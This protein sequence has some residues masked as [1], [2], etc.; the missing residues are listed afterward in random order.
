[1]GVNGAAV[2][3]ATP[4]VLHVS[5]TGNDSAT[6]TNAAPMRTISAA[7]KRAPADGTVVVS[8]GTYHENVTILRTTPVH[9]ENAPGAE[10]WLDGSRS[11][12][13]W[14][15]ASGG[16]WVADN[17]T[18]SFDSSPTLK[19]GAPDGTAAG[20]QFI[21][22][23]YPMAAHPDQVWIDGAAQSQVGS[24][25]QVKPGSFYVDYSTS[26]LYLGSNPS[27]HVVR[28][29][30]LPKAISVRAPGT[31]IK[32]INVR[33]YAP[34]VPTMGAVTVERPDVSL[35]NMQIVDNATSGLQVGTNGV[36]LT[37]LLLTR[38]GMIGLRANRANGL[39]IQGVTAR[40]NNT[41]RF[42]PAPSAG[43]T[44]ITGSTGVQ[45]VNSTFAD[46]YGTGLWFDASDYRFSVTGSRFD[47][48]SLHGL[49]LE[50]SGTG[51]V[52]NNII[53]RNRGNGL[54]IDN[55][56]KVEVW[57]NTF[58]D[59]YRTIWIVQDWRDVKPSGAYHDPNLPL[60][61]RSQNINLHNNILA[62]PAQGA[63][64]ILC[65]EDLTHRFSAEQ[66]KIKA[67]GN[68]YHRASR[69]APQWL[70]V[71]SRGVGNPTR[72]D[73][74]KGLRGGTGQERSGRVLNGEPALTDSFEPTAK[75]NSFTAK[76]AYPIPAWLASTAR[77]K[78]GAKH[79]GAWIS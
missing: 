28:A 20:W 27:G 40:N 56:D 58:R 64:C 6:G 36:K 49:F 39:R 63:P 32:G 44:K 52:G 55:T 12:T 73:T 47:N 22:P 77:V 68:V 25:G 19:A 2:A 46:N 24:L 76:S 8:S 16:R 15:A 79:L 41:E 69:Q 11:V 75:V 38:N 45:V 78:T 17:W 14:K 70:L 67:D 37:N 66:L 26:R 18:A 48:N 30:D 71:W 72:F 4:S 61:W 13:N 29:S 31:T 3:G 53:T 51:K 10:V 35:T 65:V 50:V 9:L 21:N 74:S 34:S 33:R 54:E 7:V 60:P 59:N 62:R 42:N 23:A 1:M 43:G 57:N 5:P